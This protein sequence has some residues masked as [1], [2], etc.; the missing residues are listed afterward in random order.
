MK[1]VGDLRELV[2]LVKEEL[3]HGYGTLESGAGSRHHA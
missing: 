3:S 2:T 1:L